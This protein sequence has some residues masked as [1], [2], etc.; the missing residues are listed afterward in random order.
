MRNY[1]SVKAIV[2]AGGVEAK[3][4]CLR[5]NINS[6]LHIMSECSACLAAEGENM[7]Y[8]LYAPDGETSVKGLLG[9]ESSS[10]QGV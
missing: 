10:R 6:Q 4:H 1:A 3:E 9:F 8:H 7:R 2:V 5:E